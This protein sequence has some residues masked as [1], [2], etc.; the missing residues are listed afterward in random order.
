MHVM[1]LALCLHGPVACHACSLQAWYEQVSWRHLWQSANA[2]HKSIFMLGQTSTFSVHGWMFHAAVPCQWWASPANARHV[3]DKSCLHA[4]L[5]VPPCS[6][7]QGCFVKPSKLAELQMEA[8]LNSECQDASSPM[9]SGGSSESIF[10]WAHPSPHPF[11]CKTYRSEWEAFVIRSFGM[12]IPGSTEF[13]PGVFKI[14]LLT[15][16][17]GGATFFTVQ[18]QAKA[19]WSKGESVRVSFLE[20]SIWHW[21]WPWR[22]LSYMLVTACLTD[23]NLGISHMWWCF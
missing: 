6:K 10:S 14:L 23:W 11:S 22:V 13:V 16:K 8:A 4:L 20:S 7:L 5:S 19:A 17:F 21:K 15:W 1:K 9:I 2:G 12:L 18:R 3:L